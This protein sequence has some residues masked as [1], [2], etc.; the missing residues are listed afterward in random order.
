M[1]T[2]HPNNRKPPRSSRR[3]S[4]VLFSPKMLQHDIWAKKVSY[5][6]SH[7]QSSMGDL[8]KSQFF[9]WT[10]SL[11]FH[12]RAL[13]ECIEACSI[14]ETA[15]IWW[16]RLWCRTWPF[17]C[18]ARHIPEQAWGHISTPGRASMATLA[19]SR[20]MAV[21]SEL[22]FT[23]C[24]GFGASLHS[25]ATDADEKHMK[26]FHGLSMFIITLF[27]KLPFFKGFLVGLSVIMKITSTFSCFIK[28]STVKI[29]QVHPWR[30]P[31]ARQP[32]GPSSCLS[33][34]AIHAPAVRSSSLGSCAVAK[35]ML[36]SLGIHEKFTWTFLEGCCDQQVS[37][38]QC[39]WTFLDNFSSIQ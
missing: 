2:D 5:K 12:R 18:I 9:R 27:L 10:S 30:I 11:D 34:E 31:C 37:L 28:P 15:T 35:G 20:A 6:V 33:D 7:G 26:Q 3:S 21:H 8:W 13:T 39:S 24:T 25:R 36:N 32:V 22:L 4:G 14:S 1:S 38:I 19:G 17:S 23:L 16:F 29:F